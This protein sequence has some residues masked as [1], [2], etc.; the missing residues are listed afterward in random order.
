MVE[1]IDSI[2]NPVLRAFVWRLINTFN[3]SILPIMG[4]AIILYFQDNDLPIALSSFASV[5]LWDYVIGSVII[6]LAS[7]I[8]AGIEKATRESS[9]I[10]EVTGEEILD[11]Q[12]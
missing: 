9:K 11:N 5:E 3:A 8:A 2:K 6:S 7:S 12:G 4:G 1:L 10:E